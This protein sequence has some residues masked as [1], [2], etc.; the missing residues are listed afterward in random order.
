MTDTP[1]RRRRSRSMVTVNPADYVN[2]VG[3]SFVK[4]ERQPLLTIGNRH[5]DR[6]RLGQLG[7]PHPVADESESC[8][9]SLGIT[10]QMLADPVVGCQH[11]RRHWVT[12]YWRVWRS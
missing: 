8:G 2:I 9:E 5:W 7:V 1:I 11:L 6:W 3:Q 10:S 12:A 4:H